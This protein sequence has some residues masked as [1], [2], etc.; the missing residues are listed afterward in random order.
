MMG[1]M[2]YPFGGYDIGM[3]GFGYGFPGNDHMDDDD[4][5]HI[6]PSPCFVCQTPVGVLDQNFESSVQYCKTHKPKT[7]KKTLHKTNAIKHFAQY[8]D[9]GGNLSDRDIHE[10]E[11]NGRLNVRLEAN[12]HTPTG[13][14]HMR[15]YQVA[16]LYALSREKQ[17]RKQAANDDKQAAKHQEQQ[18]KEEAKIRKEQERLQKKLLADYQKEQKKIERENARKAKV[19]QK[20]LEKMARRTGVA[21]PPQDPAAEASSSSTV[22]STP[23]IAIPDTPP[24]SPANVTSAPVITIDDDE[25]EHAPRGPSHAQLATPLQSGL[26]SSSVAAAV[27]PSLDGTYRVKPEPG[28]SSL[29]VQP[30][31]G[32]SACDVDQEPAL[33]KQ[34]PDLFR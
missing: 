23:I 4:Y 14:P 28:L 22:S 26:S 10:G 21:L 33:V 13:L 16:E 15:I 19:A 18:Q 12:P 32:N 9:V 25:D 6:E 17:A 5:G 2:A 20:E 1:A 31:D 8:K 30:S 29:E 3:G 11:I 27:Y 34:E 7:K 24:L